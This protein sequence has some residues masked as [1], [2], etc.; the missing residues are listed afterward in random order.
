MATVVE[1]SARRRENLCVVPFSLYVAEASR[2]RGGG[3]TWKFAGLARVMRL[4]G[5]CEDEQHRVEC[6]DKI[7]F[8]FKNANPAAAHYPALLFTFPPLHLRAQ[9]R[10]EKNTKML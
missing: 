1:G 5:S 8:Q 6:L 2:S 4:I 10:L 7:K 3:G 9:L